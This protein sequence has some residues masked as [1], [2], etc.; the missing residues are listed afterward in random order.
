[1]N[2]ARV[3][4]RDRLGREILWQ[5]SECGKPFNLGWGARCNKCIRD[6]ER[7]KEIMAALERIAKP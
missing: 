3:L 2:F 5:C 1:M 4:E 7:H 6:E